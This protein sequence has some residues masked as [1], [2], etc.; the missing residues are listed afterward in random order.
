[1][2]IEHTM[3]HARGLYEF[4]YC[5]DTNPNNYNETH[6]PR[7][8][9]YVPS[10][11]KPAYTQDI[12][13]DF[14]KRASAQIQHLGIDRTSTPSEKFNVSQTVSIVDDLL[15]VTK[16]FLDKLEVVD[17]GFFYTRLK[18]LKNDLAQYIQFDP[19]PP[20]ATQVSVFTSGTSSIAVTTSVITSSGFYAPT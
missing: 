1:M 10:F 12:T 14:L 6:N 2:N 5:I 19:R 3:L 8:N 4:Y 11:T 13:A 18:D 20:T 9:M 17:S 15:R 7:A 16:D